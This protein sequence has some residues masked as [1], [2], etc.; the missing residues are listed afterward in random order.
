MPGERVRGQ[1]SFF[2]ETGIL[3]GITVYFLGKIGF[4]MISFVAAEELPH[5]AGCL[6]LLTIVWGLGEEG[7]LCLSE[8]LRVKG[9]FF[10]HEP[11]AKGGDLTEGGVEMLG[12]GE[13]V[14]S[15]LHPFGTR[16]LSRI[17]GW[18]WGGNGFK[19]SAARLDEVVRAEGR[20]T[21]IIPFTLREGHTRALPF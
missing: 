20:D 8:L 21:E 3:G 12:K 19:V 6:G 4:G 1:W 17:R 5:I 2:P 15:S 14:A 7:L 16:D 11:K 13:G 9:A 18:A 10:R